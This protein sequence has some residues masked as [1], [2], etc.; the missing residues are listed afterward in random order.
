MRQAIAAARRGEGARDDL[1][2]AARTLVRELRGHAGAPEAV[3][4]QIKEILAEAG[5]RPSY[6]SP[7]PGMPVDAEALLYRDLIA[8][9]I[10]SYYEPDA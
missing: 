7:E 8:A 1:M 9:C 4:V 2:T 3:L 10:K 6:A 5:L